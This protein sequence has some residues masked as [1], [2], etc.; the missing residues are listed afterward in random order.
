MVGEF[1]ISD[2]K[3]IILP[4]LPDIWKRTNDKS[5]VY[6]MEEAPLYVCP[7]NHDSLGVIDCSHSEMPCIHNTCA[8]AE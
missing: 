8:P 6:Y 4:A 2:G 1:V 5:A 3:T 7:P